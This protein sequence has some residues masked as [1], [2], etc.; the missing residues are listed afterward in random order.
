MS[1]SSMESRS[2][3]N[4]G[5]AWAIVIAGMVLVIFTLLLYN[6][7]GTRWMPQ[8][9]FH[10]LTGWD[11][12]GCGTTRAL[13]ALLH[14]HPLEAISYNYFLVVT[15]PVLAL[16]AYTGLSKSSRALRWSRWVYS[17]AM[18]ATL[19]IASIVWAVARNILDV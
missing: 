1:T 16:I 13:Y 6:P 17:P 18:I 2:L 10:A 14:G 8:C 5:I 4:S 9:A 15:A 11:C 19:L 3:L 7:I 12:P